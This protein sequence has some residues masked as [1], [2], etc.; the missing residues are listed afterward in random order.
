M[1][2]APPPPPSRSQLLKL[3]ALFQGGLFL[4]GLLIGWGTG[5]DWNSRFDWEAAAIVKGLAAA[6]PLTLFLWLS[7]YVPWSPLVRIREFLLEYLGP[8]L[9]RCSL[10]DLLLI[11]VLAG[12][13][14][15]VL[16]RGAVQDW[17]SRWGIPAAVIVT[18]VAFGLCHALSA[19][20]FVLAA[21]AGVYLSWVAGFSPQNLVP[22]IV[23]H[24][25]YDFIALVVVVRRT[26]A[27][28]IS[29]P[30]SDRETSNEG[31]DANLPPEI[32]DDESG[33]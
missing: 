15:E 22:A 21:V 4:L 29:R 27:V 26:K 20:Y 16:F 11:A 1:I 24:A 9:R 12:I 32:P 17:A 5:L 8:I 31:C 19:A 7:L 30:E 23:A 25:G 18:N 13:T 2:Q 10:F 28:E 33:N 3:A 14:E 6:V